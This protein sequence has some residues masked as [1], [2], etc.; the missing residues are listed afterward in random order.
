MLMR[1]SAVTSHLLTTCT[2]PE[3]RGVQS[4]SQQIPPTQ[5]S[6]SF[7]NFPPAGG[8]DLLGLKPHAT[9]TAFP[10]PPSAWLTQNNVTCIVL[11]DYLIFSSFMSCNLSWLC[12][13]P[14]K[15]IPNT[16]ILRF[17]RCTF[18]M[19]SLLHGSKTMYWN[20]ESF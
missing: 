6:D 9:T 20:S 17:T 2:S 15:L 14:P 12:N 1:R 18:Y 13:I 10:H 11:L 8:D 16:P 5:E 3:L 19:N 7:W 4:R